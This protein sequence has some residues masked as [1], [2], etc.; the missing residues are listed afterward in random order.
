MPSFFASFLSG[1]SDWQW[2]AGAIVLLCALTAVFIAESALKTAPDRAAMLRWLAPDRNLRELYLPALRHAL[3]ATDRYLRDAGVPNQG[4]SRSVRLSEPRPF[5]TVWSFD[6]IAAVALI[7]PTLSFALAWALGGDT[8]SLGEAIGL[9]REAAQWQRLSG[10]LC[11]VIVI[12]CFL[13]AYRSDGSLEFFWMIAGVSIGGGAGSLLFSV[14]SYPILIIFTVALSFHAA[15]SKWSSTTPFV[16]IYTAS[17]AV[18]SETSAAFGLVSALL[19]IGFGRKY[20]EVLFVRINKMYAL[21]WCIILIVT[22]YSVYIGL[23][24]GIRD[25]TKNR[26]ALLILLVLVPLVNMP[27]DWASVGLTRLLL[28]IGCEPG[29]W[30]PLWLGLLDL[31]IGALLI[32]PLALSLI[33]ALQA[34]D[35]LIVSA[36]G[37]PIVAVLATIRG[38]AAH[39]QD[40]AN[41]WVYVTLFSTLIPSILNG[42]IGAFSLCT[43]IAPPIRR[44]MHYAV[45]Q[46][47]DENA[48]GSVKALLVIFIGLQA[49]LSIILPFVVLATLAKLITL[50]I[51]ALLEHLTGTAIDF[52][53]WIARLLP[54]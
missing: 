11:G 44:F 26:A 23:R 9:V 7:Y 22:I 30:S 34:A 32:I 39:W 16:L 10:L 33:V 28:R 53:E 42:I 40:S 36:G 49:A 43:W 12:A 48:H 13:K 18:S 41:W 21:F 27:F 20:T 8:G 38:I 15:T 29:R 24:M 51:P 37:K 4:I 52:A 31:L 50:A 46:H 5:W 45:G 35:H 2:V 17:G 3:A 25:E 47:G 1:L 6:R 54:A 14:N 19:M